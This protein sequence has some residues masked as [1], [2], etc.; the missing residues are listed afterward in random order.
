MVSTVTN[1]ILSEETVLD[2]TY[3]SA[4]LLNPVLFNQAV[5]TIAPAPEFAEV[6]TL[7][8]VGPHSALSGPIRQIKAEYKFDNI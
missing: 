3:W 7:I 4:K 8:E 5:L 6:D 1:S 2:E